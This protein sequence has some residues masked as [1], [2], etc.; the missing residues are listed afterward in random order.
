VDANVILRFL[1]RDHEALSEKARGI[2][3]AIGEGRVT[4]VLD[5]V[6]LSEA[7]FVMRSVYR[8][9]HSGIAASLAALLQPDA[10]VLP[11]KPRYLLALQL[12]AGPVPHFGDACACAAALE[13]C[14]GRILSFD[15]ELDSVPGI[16]R[17]EAP[18]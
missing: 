13:K 8:L 11:D 14:E 3:E 17:A 16:T 4:A 2:W 10:V 18:G 15:R 5:P 1:L 6:T 9:A 12:F 7:V